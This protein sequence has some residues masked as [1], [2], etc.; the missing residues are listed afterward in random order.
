MVGHKHTT[1]SFYRVMQRVLLRDIVVSKSDLNFAVNFE[2]RQKNQYSISA[3][4][5]TSV[6]LL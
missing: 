1:K 5:C 2:M 3:Y 4:N 6:N